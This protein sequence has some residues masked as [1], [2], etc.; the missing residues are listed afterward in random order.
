MVFDQ[1]LLPL[2]TVLSPLQP[3]D[4]VS[5]FVTWSIRSFKWGESGL[6]KSKGW[7]HKGKEPLK[8]DTSYSQNDSTVV[9]SGVVFAD[10]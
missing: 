4:N 6:L 8:N 10:L 2:S 3:A 5:H 9:F 7:F 1:R